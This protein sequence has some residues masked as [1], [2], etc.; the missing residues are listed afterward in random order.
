[1][2][3]ISFGFFSKFH[4]S[5]GAQNAERALPG[6]IQFP[7]QIQS[8]NSFEGNFCD[9]VQALVGVNDL[10]TDPFVVINRNQMRTAVA[11][12]CQQMSEFMVAAGGL[13]GGTGDENGVAP[14]APAACHKIRQV[15]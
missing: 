11:I 8:K 6:V 1:M 2:G 9:P 10:P 12:C 14:I 3:F 13:T 7:E 5:A 15:I 4:L